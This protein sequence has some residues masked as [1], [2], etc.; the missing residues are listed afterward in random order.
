MFQMNKYYIMK[1]YPPAFN[2]PLPM[3]KQGNIYGFTLIEICIV[4]AIIGMITASGVTFF[5]RT[6]RLWLQN[7]SQIE[8]QQEARLAMDEMTKFLRQAESPA[9]A[10]SVT[11]S[12]EAG[13]AVN[14]KIQFFLSGGTTV[15][16]YLKSNRIY[17]RRGNPATAVESVVAR[18]VSQITFAKENPQG[19]A[20]DYCIHIISMTLQKSDRSFVMGAYVHLRNP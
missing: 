1:R 16:Y 4:L 17:R 8:I 15:Q 12:Q 19:G 13:E 9:G 11:I 20:D 18:N 7:S 10:G 2:L 14:S 3:K 6:Y 5:T